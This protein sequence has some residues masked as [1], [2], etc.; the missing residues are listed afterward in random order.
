MGVTFHIAGIPYASSFVS[1]SVKRISD[2]L[3]LID[4]IVEKQCLTFKESEIFRGKLQ[5]METNMFGKI[6]KTLLRKLLFKQTGTRNIDKGLKLVLMD[7]KSWL[8]KSLPRYIS[9]RLHSSPVL[10]FTDGACEPTSGPIPLTTCGALLIDPDCQ[11][12]VRGRQLFGF[13]VR[14]DLITRWLDTGKQ[15]LVTEAELYAV[16]TAVHM[17]QH[18]IHNR[19]VLIFVDSEPALFSLI[20]GTSSVQSC[21]ELVHEYIR[22]H[23]DLQAFMWFVRIPSK[24]NPA[25]DP[26]RLHLN[27]AAATYHAEIINA[28]QPD[29]PTFAVPLFAKS[30]GGDKGKQKFQ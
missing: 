22:V 10:I 28:I 21:A 18:V 23:Y 2:M 30:K 13:E 17:W 20:R 19:R 16:V 7:L 5:F 29:V 1:N 15:Q 27:E 3:A 6:G 4:H 8:E 26:S 12:P 24:S 14:H 11:D 25:D 9:P